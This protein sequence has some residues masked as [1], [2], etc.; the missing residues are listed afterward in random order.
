MEWKST[1]LYSILRFKCPQCH[2][3]D[4]F[5]AHPFNLS[6][7]GDTPGNCPVCG[8]KYEKE[9]GFYQGAMY[10]SYA[11]GVA[12]FVTLWVAMIILFP[13]LGPTG[14]V[15][16]IL[17]VMLFGSPYFYTLSKILWANMFFP[18]DPQRRACTTAK[19]EP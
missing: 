19:T 4:F 10:I 2:E 3:G 15:L 5:V 9:P 11:I 1:K 8:L 6:K 12:V 18:Y 7:V 17:A 16:T 13:G 14:Q